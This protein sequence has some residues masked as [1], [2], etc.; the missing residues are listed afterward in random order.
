M[1]HG[2]LDIVMVTTPATST[3]EI[4]AEIN[5][6]LSINMA[7]S[8]SLV[9]LPDRSDAHAAR[10]PCRKTSNDEEMYESFNKKINMNLR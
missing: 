4:T 5:S 7:G 9:K 8:S 10:L 1:K 2:S 3:P 6:P